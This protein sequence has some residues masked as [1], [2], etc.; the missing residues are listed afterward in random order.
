[1]SFQSH[2]SFF[3][4]KSSTWGIKLKQKNS[5]WSWEWCC[6]ESFVW[7]T[8]IPLE[9]GCQQRQFF[10]AG[11]FSTWN[12]IV[13]KA[14]S[15]LR[16]MHR[17]KAPA[18]PTTATPTA[19]EEATFHETPFNSLLT[20]SF[21]P[22]LGAS[23]TVQPRTV[24]TATSTDAV[25]SVKGFTPVTLYNL[26]PPPHTQCKHANTHASTHA[27]TRTPYM[28]SCTW[29][30]YH[31]THTTL[32]IHTRKQHAHTHHAYNISSQRLGFDLRYYWHSNN[33]YNHTYSIPTQAITTTM[34]L[35]LVVTTTVIITSKQ[36]HARSSQLY[37]PLCALVITFRTG[38]LMCQ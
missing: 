17:A 36:Q 6:I 34:T 18:R 7:C 35:V 32:R 19:S 23:Q 20:S 28:Q 26:L 9:C 8:G 27:C 24:A 30:Q 31:I 13:S 12:W 10:F 14:P 22:I 1:M 25:I 16:L 11:A 29:H 3:P 4:V 21:G 33:S 38:S 15:S 37:S 2:S 5:F